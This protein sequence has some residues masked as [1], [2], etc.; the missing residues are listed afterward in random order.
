MKREGEEVVDGSLNQAKVQDEGSCKE[1]PRTRSTLYTVS[2]DWRE[3]RD[4]GNA[5]GLG[6]ET[7]FTKEKE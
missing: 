3:R 7:F 6:L 1:E 2:Q 4:Q 5:E